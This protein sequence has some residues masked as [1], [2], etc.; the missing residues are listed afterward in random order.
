MGLMI[1]HLAMHTYV[2]KNN[3]HKQEKIKIIKKKS[4]K[5]GNKIYIILKD[6]SKKKIN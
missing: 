3:E 2:N 1:T 6:K 4:K 5:K